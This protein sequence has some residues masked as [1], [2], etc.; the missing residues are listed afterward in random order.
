MNHLINYY[1][2]VLKNVYSICRFDTNSP[3]PE[4][5]SRSDFYSITKSRDELSVVCNQ[6]VIEPDEKF[7][8]DKDWRCFKID[9]ILDLSLTGIIAGISVV[10]KDSKIPIF[11]ISTYN[12]DYIL[13]KKHDLER[14][15]VSLRKNGYKVRFEG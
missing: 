6:A 10:L 3:V 5:V 7:L 15:I 9:S 2:I 13:V 14:A 8:L 4:W 11:S 1:L 12:T